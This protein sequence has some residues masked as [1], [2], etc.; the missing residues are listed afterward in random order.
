MRVVAKK[1]PGARKIVA[2]RPA[3]SMTADQFAQA[4]GAR[5][6]GALGDDTN[7][8]TLLQLREELEKRLRSTGGRP[9]LV[10]AA[11]KWRIGILQEDVPLIRALSSKA[12]IDHYKPS[13]AQIAAILVHMALKRFSA[14]EIDATIK[15][16]VTRRR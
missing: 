2:R 5:R 16:T 14:E 7:P 8:L 6:I 1:A 11:E 12:K 3:P 10:E 13:P 9:A 15:K 4:F